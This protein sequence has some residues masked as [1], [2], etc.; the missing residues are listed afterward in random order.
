MNAKCKNHQRT[1][2]RGPPTGSHLPGDGRFQP[3]SASRNSGWPCDLSSLGLCV[4]SF[5]NTW[6]HPENPSAHACV[7]MTR[8]RIVHTVLCSMAMS[9]KQSIFA[10]VWEVTLTPV[11]HKHSEINAYTFVRWWPALPDWLP[12]LLQF[13]WCFRALYHRSLV[14]D[15]TRSILH[16]QRSGTTSRRCLRRTKNPGMI[17]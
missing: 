3:H 2:G 5:P 4:F 13:H 15:C 11:S 12:F 16:P 7:W 10:G 17:V 1:T 6:Q 9:W 14:L 8:V